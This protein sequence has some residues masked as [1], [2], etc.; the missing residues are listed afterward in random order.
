MN[1]NLHP[2]MRL[3]LLP[4]RP[5]TTEAGFLSADLAEAA[6]KQRPDYEQRRS[7]AIQRRDADFVRVSTGACLPGDKL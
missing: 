5:P 7:D 4:C 6:E 3:A 2:I 1:D